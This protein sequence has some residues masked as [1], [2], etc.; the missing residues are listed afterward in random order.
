MHRALPDQL[1][2]PAPSRR[3][4]VDLG[5]LSLVLEA[6]RQLIDPLTGHYRRRCQ[7]GKRLQV[8]QID[9]AKTRWVQR[10]QGNQ[11][12]QLVL[13]KQRAAQ[14]VVDFKVPVQP[15]PQPVI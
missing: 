1:T 15:V 6:A 2:W 13:D 5:Q 3:A 4:F 12:P 8:I 9:T 14:T 10:V 11:P 7:A